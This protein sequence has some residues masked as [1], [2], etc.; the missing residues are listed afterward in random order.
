MVVE[1][2]LEAV[3]VCTAGATVTGSTVTVERCRSSSL[4]GVISGGR[5]SLCVYRRSYR[6]WQYCDSGGLWIQQS[7]RC[8]QW[9]SRQCLS[10]L[11]E[12]R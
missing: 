10:V 7:A 11:Q 2:V 12:L 4:Q 8:D 9:C 5:G 3:F 6:D 1:A